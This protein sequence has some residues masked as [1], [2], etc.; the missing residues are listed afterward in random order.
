MIV[1]Q[2][3]R[4]SIWT[5][6]QCERTIKLFRPTEVLQSVLVHVLSVL[7]FRWKYGI[8]N[9][10][11]LNEIDVFTS[12]P[13]QGIHCVYYGTLRKSIFADCV[14]AHFPLSICKFNIP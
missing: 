4:D 10:C 13:N 11:L 1:Q 3:N 9:H 6:G 2:V 5:N 14:I 12:F 7:Y 8:S